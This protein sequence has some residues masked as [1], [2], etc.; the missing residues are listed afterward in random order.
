[1]AV[2]ATSSVR[3]YTT[4]VLP[5]L[6]DPGP[7]LILV[8]SALFVLA[9]IVLALAGPPTG[10]TAPQAPERWTVVGAAGTA[11]LL[12]VGTGA[13]GLVLAEHLVVH[14]TADALPARAPEDGTVSEHAWTWESPENT[15]VLD[16]WTTDTVGIVR[17]SDGVVALDPLT[18]EE[19]WRYRR[20]EGISADSYRDPSTTVGADLSAD[21]ERVY[22]SHHGDGPERGWAVLAASTGEV[23]LS[24]ADELAG[25]ES[26]LLL[27]QAMGRL[28]EEEDGYLNRDGGENVLVGFQSADGTERWGH[29]GE[30]GCFPSPDGHLRPDEGQ[31]LVAGGTVVLSLACGV[32]Q[33]MHGLLLGIDTATG[34]EAW[35]REYPWSVSD[36]A[37][38]DEPRS[39]WFDA[40][41]DGSAVTMESNRLVVDSGTGDALY[42]GGDPFLDRG[43]VTG[44]TDR[45]Y[46]GWRCAESVAEDE[47]CASLRYEE[48]DWSGQ[49]LR[50]TGV[51]YRGQGLSALGALDLD[52]A[53]VRVAR[54]DW[55][56]R[57]D[58]LPWD[59]SRPTTVPLV[60]LEG[61]D[62][63]HSL[64]DLALLAGPGAV[65][66]YTP[67]NDGEG[68]VVMGVV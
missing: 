25:S 66:V 6:S 38:Q 10:T 48:T 11:L 56:W 49:T 35:R 20:P 8:G 43:A 50:S 46:T 39:A 57:V 24:G 68:G 17:L 55:D 4:L 29:P 7:F 18:G 45:S 64:V 12:M 5:P 14:S 52:D 61:L 2:A 42:D 13:G 65:L 63:R 21:R 22:L 30:E 1:M 47:H 27:A 53:V 37:G 19:R 67:F 15:R 3:R 28:S 26:S 9:G 33:D 31:A 58:V 62:D 40:S 44:F 36:A 51:N 32:G 54:V 60:G 23:L 16:V 41:E 59:G 34:V